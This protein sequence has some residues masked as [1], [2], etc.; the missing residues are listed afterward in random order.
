ML[1]FKCILN[2]DVFGQNKLNALK[3]GETIGL[4]KVSHEQ[5]GLQLILA[6]YHFDKKNGN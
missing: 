6:H 1:E 5:I 4:K 2:F 3:W